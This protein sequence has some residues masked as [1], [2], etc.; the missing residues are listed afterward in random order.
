[1]DTSILIVEDDAHMRSSLDQ[2]LTLS[3]FKTQTAESAAEALRLLAAHGA[4]VVLT[5]IKMPKVSG[6]ELMKRVKKD[7]PGLP[8]VLF[9]GEGDI[10]MAV[11]AMR[12]GA[13]DFLT[14][15]PYD[16]E[17][18][19][20]VLGKAAEHRRLRLKVQELENQLL[21]ASRIETRIIGNASS[22]VALRNSILELAGLPINVIVRGE[23]GTGKEEVTK[24]L[25][26]FSPRR[27]GP[28]VAINCAAVPLEMLEAELFGYEAGAFTGAAGL[29]VGKF[30]FAH[31]GTLLLDEIESMP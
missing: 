25:H 17:H 9:T 28:Y 20:A 5:D 10:P 19:V 29:R 31:G 11:S 12:E 15:T 18:L 2:W 8:V 6:L 7:Y 1:M 30:E 27:T 4:D 3:G 22:I 26:D 16:P 14:K 24:A 13:F 23:T 21:D